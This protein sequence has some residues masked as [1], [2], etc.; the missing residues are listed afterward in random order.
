M[1]FT[2]CPKEV[3]DRPSSKGCGWKGVGCPPQQLAMLLSLPGTQQSSETRRVY[4]YKR[5]ENSNDNIPANTL[6]T[7]LP[8]ARQTTL[9][10]PSKS[11]LKMQLKSGSHGGLGPRAGPTEIP[12]KI[13]L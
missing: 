3:G 8:R 7:P 4:K 2:N 5:A 13:D 12:C 9:S 1:V 10:R 6:P 11:V